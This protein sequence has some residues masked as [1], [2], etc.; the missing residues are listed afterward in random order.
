MTMASAKGRILREM[1][2]K[3]DMVRGIPAALYPCATGRWRCTQSA[4][5]ASE[6]AWVP[7]TNERSA[8]WYCG[9]CYNEF[10][11][12]GKWG[13]LVQLDHFLAHTERV[14]KQTDKFSQ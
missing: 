6:L 7:Q 14:R 8:G 4:F 10:A 3:P 1:E 9:G 5:P 11:G 12:D 2:N 13:D